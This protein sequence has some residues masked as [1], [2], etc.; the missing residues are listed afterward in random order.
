MDLEKS[1]SEITGPAQV[2]R[3]SARLAFY[4][5]LPWQQGLFAPALAVRPGSAEE[6]SAVVRLAAQNGIPV[7]PRSS[8][9][10]PLGASVPSVAGALTL[11]LSRLDHV[12]GIDGPNKKV[13]LE[14]GVSWEKIQPV[15]ARE[16]LMVCNPL[17]PHPAHSAVTSALEREPILVPKSEYSDVFMTAE[18]VLSDGGEF[19][20]GTAAGRGMRGRN[21]PD[22]FIPGTRL[23]TGAQGTLGIVTA[24]TLKA[25]WLPVLDKLFLL[26]FERLADLVEPLYA[27]QR[28]MLGQEC[29][30]LNR[31]LLSTLLGTTPRA[32]PPYAILL[33]LSGF[34]RFPEEKIAA[35]EDA[36]R[37]IAGRLAFRVQDAP[38]GPALVEKLRGPASGGI[39]WKWHARGASQGI[40]F[41]CPVETAPDIVEA[42]DFMA[43]EAGFPVDET[44]LYLQPI[45]RARACHCE[46]NIPFD[47]SDAVA[48]NL[49]RNLMPRLAGLAFKRGA[50]F[51]RP[52]GDWAEMVFREAPDYLAATRLVKGALDPAGILNP[53]KLCLQEA[54]HGS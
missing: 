24:A 25:E 31:A 48:I 34:H 45:E 21:F 38:G 41:L 7:V 52:Y 20:T 49:L 53:D 30:V 12:L 2:I 5:P 15:L 1:L 14:P 18:M 37:E 33:C 43:R 47:P 27:I 36:L 4:G 13:K 54:A 44:G 40:F 11:D 28:G 8:G 10:D 35:E 29:L 32:L 26:P 42:L 9:F 50:L 46:L 22:G 17:L 51:S 39:Y 19:M 16:G 6:V 23:F 3:E